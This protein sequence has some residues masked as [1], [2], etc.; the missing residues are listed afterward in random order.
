METK[1]QNDVT[2]GV[3]L[4]SK[5]N[6][7]QVFT[8]EDFNE[9]QQLMKAS[10]IEFIDREVWP[11]KERFE[12][13]DYA[14]TEALM[15]KAGELGFLSIPVPEN[16]GGM[17]MG[18][19][20]TMLVC[21]YMSGSSGSLSTA[22]GAHTG[23]GILPILLYG[24]ETQKQTYLPKLASGEWFASYCLT[25][26]GAGSD[27]NSGKTKAVLSED[28]THYK[29]TGQ[30]MWISN[31]GFANLFIVFA[32]IEDDK[33]ITGFL[34]PFEEN[35][36]IEL[37]EEE[38]K[39][40][41]HASST[42]QVF[43]NQ[44]K[45]PVEN[46]LGTRNGGFKIAMNALNVGRIKLGVACLDAQR[47]ITTKAIQYANERIQ[48]KKPISSFGAIQEKIAQ[49]AT[50]CYVGESSCYRAAHAIELRIQQFIDQG[51]APQEAELKGVEDF[52]I[53]CSLIKVAASEDI[54]NCA[55]HGIQI[56]GGMGFSADTPMESAWRDARI[57]RIYEGTNEINRMLAVGMLL[58]KGLKEELE[59]LPA[60][61]Q[62]AVQ[63]GGARTAVATD[64]PLDQEAALIENFKALFLMVMGNATQKY[65]TQLEEEQQVLLSLADVLI[66]IY[67]SESALLRTQKNINRKGLETQEIQIAMVQHYIFEAHELVSKKLKEVILHLAQNE[68]ERTQMMDA[69]EKHNAYTVY[70]DL[71]DL[72]TKI[73]THFIKENSYCF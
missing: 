57:G 35:N 4:L 54:Q 14:F 40:G 51:Y 21:D 72:K 18:F 63:L 32:R 41:I 36:G 11:Y 53:E 26:P 30:K 24:S 8:P 31:A 70:P 65:G 60:V 38:H 17:G 39:L 6:P 19:V 29:I 71:F 64:N 69:L 9:E 1:A 45:V 73:A 5:T 16:Y 49:M 62:A 7:A 23:I 48:F 55:D 61:M 68:A 13:K 20:S 42:R 66:E 27:A 59:L 52:A 44:T 22:F 12:K 33:N 47:R 56:L 15:K 58:K 46:V 67:F 37:G 25:E 10:V 34:V 28:G 2:G 50:S 3:F 43:F